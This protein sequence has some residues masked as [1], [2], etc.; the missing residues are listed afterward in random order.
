KKGRTAGLTAGAEVTHQVAEAAVPVA[1]PLGDR[2]QGLVLD[3]DGPQRLVLPLRGWGGAAEV[4]QAGDGVHGVAS[5]IVP[6]FCVDPAQL[7]SPVRSWR[8][9]CPGASQ[10]PS[11]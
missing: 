9:R 10:R 8:A 6:D 7:V 5:G 11:P 1:E 2:G 4:I 3:E